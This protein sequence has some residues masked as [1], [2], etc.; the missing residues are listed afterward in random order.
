MIYVFFLISG[1]SALVYQVI[2]VR[3]F[4]NIFGNTI[5]SASLVTGVFMLGI[6]L[7]SFIAGYLSDHRYKKDPRL[8]LFYYAYAEVAIGVSALFLACLFPY[9]NSWV[10]YVSH[11]QVTGNGWHELD[12]FSI[13]FRYLI[14]IALLFPITV[15]M[16]ATLTFLIRFLVQRELSDIGWKTGLLYATNTAGAALGVGLV[17][18]VLVT[19]FGLFATQTIAV[20]LNL[21]AAL[22]A[23][24]LAKNTTFISSPVVEEIKDQA[25]TGSQWRLGTTCLAIFL[26]GFVGLAME[27]I[28][29]RFFISVLDSTRAIFSLLLFVILLGFWFGSLVAG[30]LER[31]WKHAAEL[32]MVSQCLFLTLALWQLFQFEHHQITFVDYKQIF[33]GTPVWA[34]KWWEVFLLLKIIFP[35]VALPAFF[36]GFAYPLANSNAQ[37]LLGKVGIRAGSIY[38]SNMSGA[39]LGAFGAGFFLLPYLGM[40]SSLTTL[41]VITG[42]SVFMLFISKPRKRSLAFAAFSCFI[43]LGLTGLLWNTL[44]SKFILLKSL[45][46]NYTN[47]EKDLVLSEGISES[48]AIREDKKSGERTL[49]TNGHNMS[50]TSKRGQRYMRAFAHIPLLQLENPKSVL[51]ICFGVGN[52]LH[53]ASLHPSIENLEIVDTSRHVLEHASYFE[54]SN[55]GILSDPRVSVFIND[56]RLHL[57]MRDPELY[58]LITLEP[59][60]IFFAGVSALYTKEFYALAKRG[61]KEGGFCTQW[62][63]S[64]QVSGE[65]VKSIVHAFLDVFPNALLLSG[66]YDHLILMGRKGI[67]PRIDPKSLMEKIESSSALK[68]DL[69]RIG[70]GGLTEILG[71]FVASPETMRRVVSSTLPVIDDY[72]SMEYDVLL[73]NESVKPKELFHVQDANVWCPACFKEEEAEYLLKDLIPYLA[74]MQG[75][76]HSKVFLYS[77]IYH[78]KGFSR[79]VK[80]G[81]NKVAFERLVNQNWYLQSVLGFFTNFYLLENKGTQKKE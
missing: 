63:P 32:Y 65:S 9:L 22:G 36:M 27:I 72:P 47:K 8:M 20:V 54:K 80:I 52:T 28:W 34:Q 26:S 61:L 19:N 21:I 62:L 58:D 12:L 11:Y 64:S 78:N 14:A 75:I 13:A 53:A 35:V 46:G 31:R 45:S 49:Y 74:I 71:S 55:Q 56:G 77:G 39:V 25:V 41:L 59:P 76:Y 66:G 42:I 67:A 17:D 73:F 48:I 3:L 2:W 6:G 50:D 33:I 7:G 81:T 29:Y 4:G 30:F 57:R 70:M 60:P 68:A 51:V 1:I 40:Q 10:A 23:F 44:P 18:F 69:D 37:S 79:D 43:V 15:P 5:Y 38:L 24:Y 16:G